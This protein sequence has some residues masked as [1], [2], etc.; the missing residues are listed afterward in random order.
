MAVVI[1]VD[2]NVD[3][4]AHADLEWKGFLVVVAGNMVGRGLSKVRSSSCYC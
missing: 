1:V 2:I 3:V 4:D